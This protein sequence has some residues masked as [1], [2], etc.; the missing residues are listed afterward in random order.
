MDKENRCRLNPKPKLI[1]P[2]THYCFQ[3]KTLEDIKKEN[4]NQT[5][6]NS[7]GVA[8]DGLGIAVDV[9]DLGLLLSSI[10]TDRED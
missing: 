6:L 5:I 10:L 4:T 7:I 2:E 8:A 1:D 3:I 9:L